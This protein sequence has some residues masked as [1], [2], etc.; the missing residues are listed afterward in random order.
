MSIIKTD[1]LVLKSIKYGDSSKIVSLYSKEL[2]KMKVIIKSA[3]NYKSGMSG[4]FESLNYLTVILYYKKS[5]D[6]Q[7]IYKAEFIRSFGNIVKEFSKLRAAYKII[8]IL[9]KSLPDLDPNPVLYDIVLNFF[10]K[11]NLNEGDSEILLLNFQIE[12]LKLSGLFPEF[13][14][15]KGNI[16][17]LKNITE[18]NLNNEEID[19]L[20]KLCGTEFSVE[21]L[22]ADRKK[23]DLDYI[24]DRFSSY[25]VNNNSTPIFFKSDKVFKELR[26]GF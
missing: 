7:N 19:F 14:I 10:T 2:G 5:R 17:T 11:L 25:I 23:F 13:N 8:E 24:S 9:N 6:L 21:S 18:F 12:F 1:A 15:E 20:M 16:E 4:K 22:R 26:N 3:R